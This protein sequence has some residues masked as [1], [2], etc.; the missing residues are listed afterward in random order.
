MQ[1][2]H[3]AGTPRAGQTIRAVNNNLKYKQLTPIERIIIGRKSR[4]FFCNCQCFTIFLAAG[5]L[6]F[7][8]NFKALK[9]TGMQQNEILMRAAINL[10]NANI[11]KGGGP[12]GA[13]VVYQG[14]IVGRGAN[15]VTLQNDPTAHAEVLAIRDA[16][17]TLGHYD[18]SNCVLYTSCEP[19]PMCLGAIYWSRIK[20]VYYG[21]NRKDAAAAGFDD[22]FIYRE[23]ELPMAQRSILMQPLLGEEALDNFKRWTKKEDKTAY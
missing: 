12:F 2:S 8:I 14:E 22:D 10:A 15:E 3:Q 4:S 20:T 1:T 5:G 18:L 21:N 13:V 6:L 7:L 23:L 11:E 17:Q 16:A 9:K 19:C